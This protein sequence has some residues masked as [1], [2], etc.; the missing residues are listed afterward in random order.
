MA[1]NA[2]RK[3]TPKK[4]PRPKGGGKKACAVQG[5]KRAYRAKGLCFFHYAKW[6]RGEIGGRPRRW[7][8]C[9]KEE[10][11]KKA[12]AHGLCA[13]HLEAWK[14]SRKGAAPAAADPRAG[15]GEGGD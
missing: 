1:E 2:P 6:R 3:K 12:V 10:C 4:A 5:C 8:A 15:D 9:G 14:R 13:E 11:R 7:K